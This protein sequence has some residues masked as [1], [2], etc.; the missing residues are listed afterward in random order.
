M[1]CGTVRGQPG[2]FGKDKLDLSPIKDRAVYKQKV[3]KIE[4]FE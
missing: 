3:L 1:G 2:K 4:I